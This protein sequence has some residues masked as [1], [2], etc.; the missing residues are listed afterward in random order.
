MAPSEEDILKDYLL[1]PASLPSILPFD[2]FK[3]HFP[4]RLHQSPLLRALY[5]D[6]Q[7][8]RAGAM[9]VV[10]GAIQQEVKRGRAMRR[11]VAR[12]A[13][14]GGRGEERVREGDEEDDGEVEMERAVSIF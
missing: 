7:S 4:P 3:L 5:R 10:K 1:L 14:R 6:L 12:A 9:E 11:E 13:A 8:Q 2:Q